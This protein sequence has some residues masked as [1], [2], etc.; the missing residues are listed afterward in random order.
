MERLKDA[1]GC[2]AAE[3]FREGLVLL[4]WLR[5]QKEAQLEV[6]TLMHG[7]LVSRVVFPFE[8]RMAAMKGDKE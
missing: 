5:Q 1:T 8:M 2:N 3:L 4:E 7:K 6:G